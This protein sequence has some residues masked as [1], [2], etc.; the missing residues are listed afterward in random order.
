MRNLSFTHLL[1]FIFTAVLNSYSAEAQN[2][3]V[4]PKSVLQKVTVF[5][6]RAMITRESLF[7]VKKG[8]NTVQISGITPFLINE[9]VQVALTD[10]T[11]LS[12]AEVGVEETYLKKTDQ[13]EIQ[14]LLLE[15]NSTDNKI[16]DGNHQINV[17][18]SSN[19]FLKKVNPF[20]QNLKVSTTEIDAHTK[21]LE[22]SLSSNFERISLLETKIRKWIEEKTALENQLTS[23][24]SDKNK[25]KTIVIHVLS[26]K[27]KNNIKLKLNYIT[28]QAGWTPQYE[29]RGLLNESKVLFNYFAT[30]T[31]MTGEDWNDVEIEISTS[32]PFIYGNN[33]EL[34]AWYIDV[35]SP[36][37]LRSNSV[38]GY[39]KQSAPKVM[40]AQAASPVVESEFEETRIQEETTSFTFV[41]PRKV[42]ILSDGQPHKI[43]ITKSE[44]DARFNW[45]TIPKLIQSAFLKA[46]VR[47]PF[48]FPLLTGPVSVFL[49]EKMVGT[50][51]VNAPIVPDGE[52][53]LSLGIDEGIKIERKL[54][55]KYT[56][57]SGLLAKETTVSFEY[58]I[59]ITNGKS[60]SITLDLND[61][62]PISRN[63]KIKV[64]Q[65][66]PK[67]DE[68][69]LSDDGKITWKVT[70]DPGKKITIP[71]KF[72]VSYP[73]ELNISGL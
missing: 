12:I 33:P 65:I 24:K 49:D 6:D 50:T 45:Y 71:L 72:N 62:F 18:N 67:P 59:E 32:K 63:E 1:I 54:G 11:E 16:N 34:S 19:D 13:P 26:S 53:Q 60:K 48:T 64:E 58:N 22:K 73:K 9:S 55:K 42:G 36:R 56:G 68:A 47:N 14:K 57:Y 3:I 30:L 44:I 41:L 37:L 21:F 17:I 38:L 39:D 35:F 2:P 23:L 25:S 15:I 20:P 46:T 61:Q 8:E 7:S 31:Q 28:T 69:I 40:M 70:I 10:P 52:M 4:E 66:T 27:D 5:T 51:S 29:A 43:S